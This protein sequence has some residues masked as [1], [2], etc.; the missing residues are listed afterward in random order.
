MGTGLFVCGC[1]LDIVLR[2]VGFFVL[3]SNFFFSER[4]AFVSGFSGLRLGGAGRRTGLDGRVVR[5]RQAAK[6]SMVTKVSTVSEERLKA[7]DF[8]TKC[9]A[10]EEI[11]LAGAKEYIVRGGRDQF[12]NLAC[13]FKGVKTVGVIGWGSQGPAQAQN[14][15]DSFESAGLDV[16]VKIGLREGSS[17]MKEAEKVGFTK[18]NGTLGEMYQVMKES[19]MVLLLISDAAQASGYEKIQAALKPG[20]TLGLSHGFLLGHLDSLGVSFRDDI[21]II[22]VAPKGM[23]PSVRRLY[24]Q[25]K[26]VNGA[27]INSSF[28]V[29]QDVTGTATDLAIGWAVAIGSPFCFQTT[30]RNEYRSDIFGE[31]GMLH[32]YGNNMHT[33]SLSRD[34]SLFSLSVLSY[35]RFTD[36]D[37]HTINFWVRRNSARGRPWRC[38]ST[39]PPLSFPEHVCGGGLHQVMREHHWSDQFFDLQGGYQGCVRIVGRER[40][41][42]IRKSVRGS[43]HAS[44]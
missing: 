13:A 19:D 17:S 36:E 28:A 29:H 15:R 39:F 23:G 44:V 2:G 32:R 41:E 11:E 16:T 18:E 31:R 35:D 43:I 24:V 37:V 7:K 9:F 10:K 34:A 5:S 42:N 25:G 1:V 26:E 21:N 40:Q 38:R 30:L 22:L 14:L 27:G 33:L 12:K 4:M 20:A 8:D 6:V 3:L